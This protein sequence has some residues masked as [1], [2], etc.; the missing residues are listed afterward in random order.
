[1]KRLRFSKPIR[2]IL[3][4]LLFGGN[5][6]VWYWMM[7]RRMPPGTML[8][9]FFAIV[10][11][12]PPLLTISLLG[13]LWRWVQVG[14]SN[15]GEWKPPPHAIDLRREPPAHATLGAASGEGPCGGNG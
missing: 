2:F 8:G 12:G 13:A 6:V 9:P 3:A 1:M 15:M 14:E 7:G 11:I 5:C 10:M 4:I